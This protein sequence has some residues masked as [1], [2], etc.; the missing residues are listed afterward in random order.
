MHW[1]FDADAGA[2]TGQVIGGNF[3][4][5]P[6][7]YSSY[8]AIFQRNVLRSSR[9][10]ASEWK[11]TVEQHPRGVRPARVL[12]KGLL[13]VRFPLGRRRRAASVRWMLLSRGGLAA[14]DAKGRP[15]VGKN[16]PPLNRAAT[17]HQGILSG[18]QMYGPAGSGVWSAPTIDA[19]RRWYI[20]NRRYVPDVKSDGSAAHIALDWRTAK[21]KA[22]P[23]TEND[24]FLMGCIAAVRQLPEGV[25]PDHIRASPILFTCA[26][27]RNHS[28][29]PE[30]RH[31]L[32]QDRPYGQKTVWRKKGAT[33][34]NGGIEWGMA[35][36]STAVRGGGRFRAAAAEGKGVYRL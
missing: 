12:Y 20:G 8:P 35:A 5:L 34:A 3:A 7:G 19:K 9:Q 24:S 1:R 29:G 36:I 21:S 25:G 31:R 32:W 6:S 13:Y 10:A 4:A 33:E 14:I 27:A 15:T 16:L 26:T 23:V 17:N 30:I 2:D 18:T 22:K 11:M 28:G